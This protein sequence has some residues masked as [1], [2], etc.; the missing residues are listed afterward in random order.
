MD[1]PESAAAAQLFADLVK[2]KAGVLAGGKDQQSGDDIFKSPED[3]HVGKRYL[4]Y[5]RI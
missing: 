5:E 2:N 3:C 4:A 1:S